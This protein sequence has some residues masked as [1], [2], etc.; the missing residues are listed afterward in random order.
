M[1]LSATRSHLDITL[2]HARA[3]I[4]YILAE[5]QTFSVC[6]CDTNIM[7]VSLNGFDH[8]TLK[9]A[10]NTAKQPKS[11]ALTV[12]HYLHWKYMC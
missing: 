3:C 9:T 8:S 4:L 7:S 1:L 10:Y 5:K 6:V 12:S 11:R 2:T